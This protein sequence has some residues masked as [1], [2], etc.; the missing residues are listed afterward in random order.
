MKKVS[1]STLNEL[2]DSLYQEEIIDM[3]EKEAAKIKTGPERARDVIDVVRNKGEKPSSFL[4]RDLHKL[5][6]YLFDTLGLS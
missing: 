4:I 3:E 2:L 1:D 6:P 5:D